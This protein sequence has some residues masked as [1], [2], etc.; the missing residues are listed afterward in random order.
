MKTLFALF[1]FF[2]VMSARS[3]NLKTENFCQYLDQPIQ[4]L[5][6]NL[7][8]SVVD[9][10]IGKTV[11]G[12]ARKLLLVFADS[13]YFEIF[14]VFNKTNSAE[15]FNLKNYTNYKIKCIFYH[16][17]GDVVD[18]CGCKNFSPSS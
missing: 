11:I 9:A 10:R 15:K 17:P 1:F 7:K 5:L 6:A 13:S 14:P 16:V 8:T 18:N 4:R 2:V 3:Q 12:T